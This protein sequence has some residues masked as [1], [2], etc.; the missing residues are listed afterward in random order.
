M[1]PDAR[2]NV[3]P[4]S[5][6]FHNGSRTGATCQLFYGCYPKGRIV[7]DLYRSR[8]LKGPRARALAAFLALLTGS[9]HIATL[10]IEPLSAELLIGVGHGVILLLIALGLMGTARFSLILAILVSSTAIIELARTSGLAQVLPA[11]E[12]ALLVL[13]GIALLK[14]PGN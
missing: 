14:H 5:R 2:S 7:S 9:L 3:K 12:L 6:E 4:A 1:Q 13:S 10:W 8:G 11:I